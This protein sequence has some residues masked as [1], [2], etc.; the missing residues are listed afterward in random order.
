MLDGQLHPS[1]PAARGRVFAYFSDFIHDAFMSAVYDW[2]TAREGI[3]DG[4]GPIGSFL[5]PHPC[6]RCCRNQIPHGFQISLQSRS[7]R[8]SRKTED[9]D[10]LHR[11]LEEAMI[12][13]GQKWDTLKETAGKTARWARRTVTPQRLRKGAAVLAVLAAV[14]TAGSLGMLKARAS[15]RAAEDMARTE[16][17]Q[18]L[19]EQ[20][21]RSILSTDAVRDQVAGLIGTDADSLQFQRLS[22]SDGSKAPGR[23]DDGEKAKKIKKERQEKEKKQ[24]KE[25]QKDRQ[26]PQDRNRGNG[27]GEMKEGQG[28]PGNAP[29]NGQGRAQSGQRQDMPRGNAP[30]GNRSQGN[31]PQGNGNGPAG[32]QAPGEEQGAPAFRPDRPGTS[33]GNGQRPQ[34][35]GQQPLVYDVSAVNN[36]MTYRFAID[37][38]TGKVMRSQV[39]QTK[40]LERFLF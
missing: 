19:A 7:L 6:R 12:M 40:L 1:G 2:K 31:A 21:H 30:Q 18:K 38:E 15:Q 36:G 17:L 22:L 26:M 10:G 8:S 5:F 4:S 32:R 27:S 23:K 25:G 14:G 16:M 29:A 9:P 20:Q 24:E 34:K 13:D 37:A 11:I 35:E 39:H 33:G 3:T 28:F